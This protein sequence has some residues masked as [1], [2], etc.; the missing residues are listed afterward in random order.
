MNKDQLLEVIKQ[1]MRHWPVGALKYAMAFVDDKCLCVDGDY[2]TAWWWK[3][4]KAIDAEL[5]NR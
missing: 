1:D 3:L 2:D 5:N 4:R